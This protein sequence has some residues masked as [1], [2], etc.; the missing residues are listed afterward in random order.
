MTKYKILDNSLSADKNA[1]IGDIVYRCVGY[2]YGCSSEDTAFRGFQ[3][4]SVTF[5]EDG[6]YPFFTIPEKHLEIVE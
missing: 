1:K 5:N 2:D 6:S 4:I 3:H